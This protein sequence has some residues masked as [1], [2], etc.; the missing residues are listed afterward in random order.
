MTPYL[1]PA[2]SKARV[3]SATTGKGWGGSSAAT[4]RLSLFRRCQYPDRDDRVS[5]R[6]RKCFENDEVGCTS[7]CNDLKAITPSHA[8]N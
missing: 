7:R 5:N 3:S 4:P 6:G 2:L 1:T 8:S